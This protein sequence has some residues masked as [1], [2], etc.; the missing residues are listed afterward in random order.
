[1]GRSLK[2]IQPT[3]R[4]ADRAGAAAIIFQELYE[5]GDRFLVK[6]IAAFVLLRCAITHARQVHETLLR[7]VELPLLAAEWLTVV[8]CICGT[9][10][11]V[12]R[13]KAGSRISPDFVEDSLTSETSTD[14][15]TSR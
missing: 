11:Y 5:K 15:K 4:L 13:L 1:M 2:E 14:D 12:G 7:V 6:V 9:L 10:A 8:V 3:V